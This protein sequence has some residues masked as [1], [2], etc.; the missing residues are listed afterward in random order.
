[1]VQIFNAVL[2]LHKKCVFHG[3]L[4]LENIMTDFFLS[5][6]EPT[7]MTKKKQDNFIASLLADEKEIK[8][9]LQ[10]RDL[11]R[12]NTLVPL[13]NRSFNLNIRN[14]IFSKEKEGKN[15]ISNFIYYIRGLKNKN[16]FTNF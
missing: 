15:K 9:I 16:L 11:R 14:S 2:Y 10:E 8:E 4:K 3:D 1:M 12:A 7:T 6:D 13:R 5:D